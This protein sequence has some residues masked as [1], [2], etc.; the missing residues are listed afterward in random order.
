[1]CVTLHLA[2]CPDAACFLVPA[3]AVSVAAP[4]A[5]GAVARGVII[6]LRKS[7]LLRFRLSPS[8]PSGGAI[9]LE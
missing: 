3:A 8:S 6:S 1:M 5:A 7:S 9:G 2:L 4:E